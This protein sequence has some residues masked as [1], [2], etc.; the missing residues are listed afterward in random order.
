MG[1]YNPI[2]NLPIGGWKGR[3]WPSGQPANGHFSDR[4][5]SGQPLGRLGQACRSTARS[6]G[7]TR[8]MGRNYQ[9]FDLVFNGLTPY[10]SGVNATLSG[11]LHPPILPHIQW[12]SQD[13][14]LF[15]GSREPV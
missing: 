13:N 15:L 14:R 10:V 4:W 7:P 2:K 5:A 6:T 11:Q 12:N 9:T 1:I 3:E 8:G